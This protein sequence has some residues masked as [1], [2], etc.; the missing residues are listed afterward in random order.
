MKGGDSMK[1]WENPQMWRLNA[2]HTMAGG[3]GGKGD[4]VV[5]DVILGNGRH[6]TLIGTSGPSISDPPWVNPLLK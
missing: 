2:E 3:N 1:Q 6:Q 5:Y 4:G